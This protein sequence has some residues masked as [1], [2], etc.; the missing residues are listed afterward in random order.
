MYIEYGEQSA[1]ETV[2]IR[3]LRGK[4]LR[5][6]AQQGKPLAITKAGALIGVVIPVAAAWVENL[7]DYNWSA[8]RQSITEGEQAAA[9]GTRLTTIADLVAS[10]DAGDDE[11]VSGHGLPEKLAVPTVVAALTGRTVAQAPESKEILAR[12]QQA[13]NPPSAAS[14]GPDG[15]P[16]GPAMRTVRVG[17]LSADEIEQAGRDGQTLAVTHNR[18]LIGIIIPVTRD[19]V[20]F[21]IEQNMSRILQNIALSEK[22]SAQDQMIT[23]DQVL[24]EPPGPAASSKETVNR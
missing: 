17:D 12:L 1:M 2:N 16:A 19:L 3:N 8:V 23:L 4:Y 20:E 11:D 24:D 9:A 22:I 13:F 5:E 15:R 18:K 14:A 21:L 6:N 10:A 7:I